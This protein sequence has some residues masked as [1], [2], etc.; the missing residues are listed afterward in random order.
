MANLTARLLKLALQVFPQQIATLIIDYTLVPRGA[1]NAPGV[2]V[3]HDH[4]NKCN[5]PRLLQCQCWVSLAMVVESHC[6]SALT[7][8]LRSWLVDS[9]HNCGKLQIA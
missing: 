2:A 1:A 4:A 8:P 7:V 6:G 9:L 5:R 3:R